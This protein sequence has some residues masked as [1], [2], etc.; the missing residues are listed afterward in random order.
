M[1]PSDCPK[2]SLYIME[3]PTTVRLQL[4]GVL[5]SFGLSLIPLV[6]NP[7]MNREI[8]MNRPLWNTQVVFCWT[9]ASARLSFFFHPVSRVGMAAMSSYHNNLLS[10]YE[11]F[12]VPRMFFSSRSDIS[13]LRSGDFG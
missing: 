6:P 5:A 3:K 11:P 9:H 10:S 8:G 7:G 4:L 13:Q 2:P 1:S 12:F